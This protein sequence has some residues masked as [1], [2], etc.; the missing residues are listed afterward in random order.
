[1][2]IVI[3]G[4]SM[5]GLFAAA[6]L[7]RA[8]HTVDVFERSRHGLAGRGA[9]LVAQGEVGALLGRIGRADAARVG[10]T[11]SERII[12]GDD[13]SIAHRDPIPQMQISW[14]HLYTVLRE[15]VPEASH[16]TG[17]AVTAATEDG[18]VTLS[19]GRTLEAD[20]V[21][22]ADGIGSALRAAV[23]PGAGGPRYAGYVAWRFLIPEAALPPAAR[24]LSGRFAF[25]HAEGAQALGYLV[26][27]PAGET[28]P[29]ARRYNAVWYRRAA[30]LAATLTDADGRR[31]PF[32]L[33]PGQLP[34]AARARLVAAA[35]AALPPAFA[36]VVAAEPAPF[37]QAIFDMDTPAMARGALALIGDAAFVVRPHTA[38]GVAKAAGDAMALA[39]A[40]SPPPAPAALPG[41]LEAW[42]R[43][44]LRFGRAVLTRGLRLG[45]ALEPQPA[46]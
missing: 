30:D 26:P 5:A 44:R 6:L 31:H 18:R 4:G 3:A 12:L 28:A 29:G 8:G 46:A 7:A 36:A 2:R 43:P 42:A 15:E 13:G 17:I 45:A 25:H 40:L 23:A 27:G 35:R 20:L 11:A 32:S 34:A 24:M 10:V 39:D 41:V 38:M 19:D 37:V 14:D 33:A 16:H 1:M 9:G 21:I 22:G